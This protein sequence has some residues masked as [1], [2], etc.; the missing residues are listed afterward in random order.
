MS[1]PQPP[2]QQ[3]PYYP[4]VAPKP[5]GYGMAVA[6]MVIGICGLVFLWVPFFGSVLSIV[7]LVLGAVSKKKLNETGSPSGMA[8]AGIVCSVVALAVT[9][10]AT[11]VCI[12]CICAAKDTINTFPYPN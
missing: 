11:I 12:S 9:V 5:P 7:G 10:I 2:Y 3:G 1:N 6:S 8:T 4:P